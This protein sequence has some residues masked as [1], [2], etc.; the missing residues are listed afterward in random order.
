MRVLLLTIGTRGDVQPYVALAHGLQRAGHTATVATSPRYRDLLSARGLGF[1]PL[2]DDLVALVETPEGRAAIAAT[3]N[4]VAGL[5]TVVRL[6]RQT[7]QIQRDLVRDGWAAAE[8]VRPHVIVCHPKMAAGLWYGEKLGVP[9]VLA[10]LFPTFLPTA[11]FPHPG[12]PPLSLGPLT[13]V[14]HRLTYRLVLTAASRVSARYF[15]PWRAAHGLPPLGWGDD[16]L[17]R[18]DGTRVPLL[19]AW[20][21]HVVPPPADWP[22]AG[23]ATTGFWFVDDATE[24]WTPPDDLAAFLDAGPPPVYVGFGSMA[25]ADPA[26]TTRTVLAALRRTGLRGVLTR[27]WGGL[28]AADVPPS[29]HVLDRAPHAWLFPRCAAVVHHGGAGTTAAGLRAG[30][31]TVVCPFFGDQPFWGRR[32]E[33]LGAGP[34]P[35][36][37]KRLTPARLAAAL[38][39]ATTD[40][41]LRAAARHAGEHLRR[42]DGVTR[43]VD[44]LERL[45]TSGGGPLAT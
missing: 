42:E 15:G 32:V 11:A 21:P 10:P 28:D 45:A 26:A 25:G 6:A 14:Y 30:R 44:A 17:H 41:S 33:A 39:R 7:R 4:L 19:H 16:L 40:A 8:A 20:S 37:Q 18:A 2:S 34:P 35:V 29:V 36:P 24:D 22:D 3:T 23:V 5:R 31:P 1:A 38:H 9:A 27:G 43:A 13:G 12:F